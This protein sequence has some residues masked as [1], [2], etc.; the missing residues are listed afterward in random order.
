MQGFI[1]KTSLGRK[2]QD[3]RGITERAVQTEGSLMKYGP[4]VSTFR[5][6]Y[7]FKKSTSES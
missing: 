3:G 6:T 1:H 7:T 2:V 4:N 5:A